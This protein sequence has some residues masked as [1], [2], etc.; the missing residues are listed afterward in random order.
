MNSDRAKSF[1]NYEVSAKKLLD[2]LGISKIDLQIQINKS[3]YKLSLLKG[4]KVIKEYPVVLGKNPIDDKRMEGDRCTPEGRFKIRDL[5]PHKSWSK[6][7]WIDYPTKDS[8]KKFKLSKKN[9]EIPKDA[10]IGGEVGIHGVP[11]GKDYL[12]DRSENWTWGCISLKN[13][14]VNDLYS[15][16]FKGMNIEILK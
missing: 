4:T 15:V 2:S 13:K 5:Y 16:C 11:K 9:G 14:D 10:T 8:E 6:F 1:V 3:A 12:I 7:I